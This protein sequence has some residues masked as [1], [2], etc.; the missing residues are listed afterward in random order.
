[1]YGPRVEER[2]VQSRRRAHP[3]QSTPR[4]RDALPAAPA[5]PGDPRGPQQVRGRIGHA[6]LLA[7]PAPGRPRVH[8]QGPFP[9][10]ALLVAS[11]VTPT[12]QSAQTGWSSCAGVLRPPAFAVAPDVI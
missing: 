9:S 1:A 3:G 6:A 12:A 10:R 4:G 2:R 8:H 7:R 5:P 11:L